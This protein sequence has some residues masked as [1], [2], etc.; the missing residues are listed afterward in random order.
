MN[1]P[2]SI[3]SHD[4]AAQLT[5]L[6]AD[7]FYSLKRGELFNQR[8]TKKTNAKTSPHVLEFTTRFNRI[9][10]WIARSILR[11]DTA[12]LRA[13]AW[14]YFISLAE[15]LWK[16]NNF[17]AL[18][19]VLSSFN[20]SSLVR[21]RSTQTSIQA[22]LNQ[23]QEFLQSEMRCERAYQNYR[24]RLRKICPPCI[25]Y[26]GMILT[27]LVFIEDGNRTFPGRVNWNKLGLVNRTVSE[28]KQ[29][30]Q[31]KYQ[32]PV[33]AKIREVIQKEILA[34]QVQSEEVLY[35]RS[36]QCEPRKQKLGTI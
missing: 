6:D 23:V 30:Q 19:A 27:N 18:V 33:N 4:L 21:L 34:I 8:W 12:K 14:E 9:S 10:H 29:F 2:F 7:L 20:C 31:I 13:Q 32:L 22:K 28:V 15:E 11:Y 26:F 25:P 24:E 35:Q 5:L 17:E 1:F 36:L 16:L 3:H